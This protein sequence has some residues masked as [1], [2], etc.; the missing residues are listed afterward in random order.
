MQPAPPPL[1]QVVSSIIVASKS[2]RPVDG[3]GRAATGRGRC[4]RVAAAQDTRTVPLRQSAPDAVRLAT[5]EGIRA[6]RQQHRAGRTDRLGSPLAPPAGA[7]TLPV[8]AEEQR[9]VHGATRGVRPPGPEGLQPRG[10]APCAAPPSLR[11]GAPS[12]RGGR[13]WCG[14][15]QRSS[16]S[17]TA[18]E[19]W[20]TRGGRWS[21]RE[22]VTPGAPPALDPNLGHAHRTSAA[23]NPHGDQSAPGSS[24]SRRPASTSQAVAAG[25]RVQ[26][27]ARALMPMTA[28]T[29]RTTSGFHRSSWAIASAAAN[30]RTLTQVAAKISPTEATVRPR[31]P[32]E[33]V[34]ALA[35]RGAQRPGAA[36]AVRPLPHP[37]RAEEHQ[38][39]GCR[40]DRSG[41]RRVP[42]GRD[43]GGQSRPWPGHRLEIGRGGKPRAR[44]AGT[45][46]L[47]DRS[48]EPYAT[49]WPKRIS[50]GAPSCV[51]PTCGPNPRISVWRTADPRRPVAPCHPRSRPASTSGQPHCPPSPAPIQPATPGARAHPA[52]DH[53]IH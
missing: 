30:T 15:A 34:G 24:G 43:D 51:L 42:V 8:T 45:P 20:R 52:Q 10:R 21:P 39:R 32:P 29:A 41:A 46:P 48:P 9:A 11:D 40:R 5:G 25:L 6:A 28:E 13:P 33:P 23:S 44:R 22:V 3:S 26:P 1:R 17:S 49:A 35:G 38:N 37:G 18:G 31:R 47:Q 12:R 36:T 16:A 27:S 4:G 19:G 7:P 2:R 50:S 53:A 14:E